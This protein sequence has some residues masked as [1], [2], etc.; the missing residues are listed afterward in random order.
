MSD[1]EIDTYIDL[2]NYS[3]SELFKSLK[4]SR[5]SKKLLIRNIN[6]FLRQV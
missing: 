5:K 2:E 3:I 6:D 1:T 4:I